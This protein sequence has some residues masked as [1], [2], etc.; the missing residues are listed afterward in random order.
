MS[1]VDVPAATDRLDGSTRVILGVA[2]TAALLALAVF[3]G[4]LYT[5]VV[6]AGMLAVAL[7]LRALRSVKLAWW[8]PDMRDVAAIAVSYTAVVVACRVAFVS[9][10]DNVAGLFLSFAVAGLLL[11]GVAAPVAYTV[12]V[13]GRSLR[14]LGVGRHHWRQTVAWGLVFAVV[15]F[16]LTLWGYRLPE[17][18]DWVPLLLMSITVGL[19]EAIFFRGFVQNRLEAMFG[20]VIGIAAAA[21]L[22]GLY[23]VGYGMGV[24]EI[25]FLSG[26]GIVYAVAFRTTGNILVLWPLLTPLGSFFNNL[27]AG[28]I[29]LPWASMAGFGEV[30]VAMAGVLWLG[31]RLQPR[32]R[33]RASRDDA[34]A[35]AR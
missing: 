20:P 14:S 24:Q 12:A 18:V 35:S 13:R 2:T 11:S 34:S 29:P 28:D 5:V 19:F 6:S 26:L 4:P 16:A 9:F 32:W 1:T 22:Y 3:P 17:P 31:R 10:S 33:A 21:L 15:Q 8:R 30:L 25:L 7:G 23:H 27:R